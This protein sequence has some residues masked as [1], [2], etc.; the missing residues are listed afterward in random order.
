MFKNLLLSIIFALSFLP[1]I[2]MEPTA[3]AIVYEGP[4]LTCDMQEIEIKALNGF[5]TLGWIVYKYLPEQKAEITLFEVDQ[6]MRNNT[7][8]R[9]GQHLFQQCINDAIARNMDR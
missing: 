5:E 7:E 4:Q 6:G 3:S 8:H 9:I 2:S 1:A